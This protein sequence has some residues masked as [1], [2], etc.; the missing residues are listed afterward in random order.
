MSSSTKAL[1]TFSDG[2][3]TEFPVMDGS[4]GPKVVDI[5]S[6]YG[7]TGTFT[8]DF[9]A[10]VQGGGDLNLVA[11]QKVFCQYWSRDVLDLAG[12]GSSLS[13]GL[14]FVICN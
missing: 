9:N 4:I 10:L 14:E 5:R 11:G 1:L 7:K 3:A 8:Y 12:F 2:K 6:L 13:N